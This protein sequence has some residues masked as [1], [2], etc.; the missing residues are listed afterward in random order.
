MARSHPTLGEILKQRR[1]ELGHTL[2]QVGAKLGL[3]NGNFIGMVERGERMPSDDRLLEM[4][5]ILDLDGRNLIAMKYEATHGAAA[6]VLLAPPDPECPRLRRLLLSTC[7]NEAQMRG[8][9]ARGERTAIERVV[10]Q[11]LLEYVVLPGL[12]A[13]RYAPRRVRD[14]V[15][16]HRK[17]A[18]GEPFDPWLFEAEAESFVPWAKAQFVSWT[19]DVP[20]LTISIRHSEDEGDLST[21]PLVDRELRDRM[22]E[23]ARRTR[24]AASERP[25]LA[26]LLR[27]EGLSDADVGEIIELVE[28]K[29]MRAGR[30]AS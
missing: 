20:T 25:T 4:G 24:A 30:S 14:K 3:A 13:D 8:E 26:S 10:V 18:P 22:L 2:L 6:S 5:R 16:R 17:R 1:K 27:E 29:K 7:G 19:L 28:F 12:D 21:I 15:A 9:F 23:S 11:A